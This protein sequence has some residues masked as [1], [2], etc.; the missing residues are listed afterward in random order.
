MRQLILKMLLIAAV[1]WPYAQYATAQEAYRPGANGRLPEVAAR[2]DASASIQMVTVGDVTDEQKVDSKSSHEGLS[3]LTKSKLNIN[4]KAGAVQRAPR[5]APS[6]APPASA[7]TEQW[8]I[9][10]NFYN[11]GY[12]GFI[13]FGETVKVAIDGNNIYVAGLDFWLPD[14]WVQGTINGDIATFETGQLFGTDS[15][16]NADYFV[17]V[18]QSTLTITDVTF[19]FNASAKKLTLTDNLQILIGSDT[20]GSYWAY[21]VNTVISKEFA[22]TVEPV[23]IADG[24]SPSGIIPINGYWYDRSTTSQIIYPASMLSSFKT[25]QLIKSIT[26]YAN[27]NGIL[28]G[29]TNAGQVT[30]TLGTTTSTYFNSAS[31]LTISGTTATATVVPVYGSKTMKIEFSTPLVYTSGTNLIIQ[32]VNTTTGTY[33]NSNWLGV[34]YTSGNSTYYSY[35]SRSTTS[36]YS[37]SANRF[38]FMPKTTFE[39]QNPPVLLTDELDF[40]AVEVGSSSTLTAYVE[41]PNSTAMTATITTQSP[42]SASA[43]MTMQPGANA[44]NVTF[45]PDEMKLYNGTLS[46][47]IDGT[48][49]NIPLKGYGNVASAT[50]VTHDADFFAGISY[51]WMDDNG[52]TH[53]STLDEIATDP[54]Q[55]I[56]M[57]KEVYTNRTIPGNWKR[58]YTSTGG[59]EPWD[60]VYYGGVGTI[61]RSSKGYDNTAYYSYQN[62]YGW[63]IPGNIK[64]YN[65]SIGLYAAYMDTTQYKPYQQGLTLLLVEMKDDFSYDDLSSNPSLNEYVTKSI[66]SVRVVTDAT[67]SGTGFD[68]GTLFKIDCDKMNKFFLLAK[69]QLRWVNNARE[70]FVSNARG[71]TYYYL[72]DEIAPAAY[73]YMNSSSYYSNSD[74]YE[75]NIFF[76]HYSDGYYYYGDPPFVDNY[77][78]KMFYHMFEQFSP[79]ATDA[80]SGRDDIYQDL[81]NMES[82]GV[83]HDCASIPNLNHQFLMY[84]E[85]SESADCQDVRDLMFFIPDYRMMKDD[86]RDA[87]ENVEKFLYY[88]KEHQPIMGLYVIR[89][90]EITPTKQE[91]G[92][93]RLQLNWRTNLDDFLPSEEQEFELFEVV[94]DDDGNTQYVP[95]Y[96]LDDN[97]NYVDAAGNPSETPV[98]IVL[99]MGAGV[100]KNYPDVW[101]QRDSHGKQVTY[102]V[103]GH[104]TGNFLSLQMSNTMSYLIPGLDPAEMVV[105]MD[106]THYSRFNP[107]TVKNCYSNKMQMSNAAG[108]VRKDYLSAGAANPTVFNFTRK[109]AADAEP[110][111]V[112]Q[113]KVTSITATGGTIA[114]EM[115][116]QAEASEFPNGQTSGTAAGYHANKATYNFTF[117]RVDAIDYVNFGNFII[118]D[119]FV[120]DVSE[121]THPSQYIYQVNFN[122][123]EQ[124]RDLN[125]ELTTEAYSTTFRVPVYKTASQIN[126][127]FTQDEVD[128]ETENVPS[129]GIDETIEFG[130]DVQYSSK[131][132]ILRYDAYRWNDG[133][134]RHIIDTVDGDDETDL[135]PTGLAMNQDGNYTISMNPDTDYETN[136]EQSVAVGSNETATFVDTYA[137]DNTGAYVYAPVVETFTTGKDEDGNARRDYNTYGGPLQNAATGKF[138]ATVVDGKTANI[139]NQSEYTWTV[140]GNIYSYY[141]IFLQYTT[142]EVPEGYELYKVRAWR[143]APA[144]LLGEKDGDGYED[145]VGT[146]IGDG[147]N[148]VLY[149]DITH[150]IDAE[151]AIPDLNASTATAGTAA[152]ITYYLVGNKEVDATKHVLR[153]TFGARMVGNEEG[154]ISEL[155]L[156]FIV[157]AYFTRNENLPA[158]AAGAPRRAEAASR[159]D[160]KFYIVEQV[161][162]Y[163]LRNENVI[164]AVDNIKVQKQVSNVVYYDMTGKASDKPF[165]GIN[166]VVTRYTDGSVSTT[167]LVK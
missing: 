152:G 49:V 65:N 162:P 154:M 41:N 47:E 70:T 25:G 61:D 63:N 120:V 145:R 35:S 76:A 55:I 92:Y 147:M 96:Y 34:E 37:S 33:N 7:T 157:R 160:G 57:L 6:Y 122:A 80:E 48:I 107:E 143:Q 85:D 19:K 77:G 133:E 22:G 164:T 60:D 82:F 144:D 127:S 27:D 100:E 121:N 129:L 148:S 104:D 9:A 84:G 30:V 98:P 110:V 159:A 8:N 97:G 5:K 86:D 163:T 101:V 52:K 124:F 29:Q 3:M 130:V 31:A 116:N 66:K 125:G 83:E 11:V 39:L 158:E 64:L 72:T 71:T 103:R 87:L 67:R 69:G 146:S 15:D 102:A 134:A 53:T 62:E 4:A 46:V 16:G 111:L 68:A 36:G 50:N 54:Q 17:G 12:G 74:Y 105:L 10:T 14:A 135:A 59:S 99:H 109:T 42:F 112:A 165:A 51:D 78:Y 81:I 90:D 43:S 117:N 58:G 137:T 93:Y 161:I 114:V 140:D 139:P 45:S 24:T 26:F 113:A 94:T 18:N 44:I 150:G 153:A 132:E 108:G 89:Q 91:E 79:V 23:N 123:A 2:H 118:Y 106:L 166:V 115:F 141:N 151:C 138:S 20:D 155:P 136:G 28:F 21:H 56:S 131:T 142:A 119:N 126:G 88:N 128:G 1:A 156:N 95:V 149:E 75:G 40:G 167:K 13:T 32:L 38:R 73:Y